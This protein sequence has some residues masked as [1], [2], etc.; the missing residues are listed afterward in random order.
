AGHRAA[1]RRGPARRPHRRPAHRDFDLGC[2]RERQPRR[3]ESAGPR[4]QRPRRGGGRR[5]GDRKRAGLL[6]GPGRPP[7]PR[8]PRDPRRLHHGPPVQLRRRGRARAHQAPHQ[9]GAPRDGAHAPRAAGGRRR[10]AVDAE[11][12][13]R[14]WLKT[15][16]Y[17]PVINVENSGRRPVGP[18]GALNHDTIAMLALDA[19]GR[20]SGSCTTSGM[21]FKMRGRVGDSPLIGSG[22]FVDPAVG[23][24][25]ATGQG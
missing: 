11:K 8:R 3:L 13:Y 6:R 18:V 14:E 9:R 12:A 21:A 2:R 23:A 15:S 10:A 1:R 17:K 7:R 5:D 19:Q 16:Q 25:A 20:L 4:R 22:L 24:A